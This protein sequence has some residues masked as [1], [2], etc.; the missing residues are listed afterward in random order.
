MIE[1]LQYFL[2]WICT[3]KYDAWWTGRSWCQTL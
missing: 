1:L 3:H 2:S